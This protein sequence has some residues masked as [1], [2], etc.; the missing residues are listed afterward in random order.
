MSTWEGC[1]VI[2]E[3]FVFDCA[4]K[5]NS[6]AQNPFNRW[7]VLSIIPNDKDN[8][9]NATTERTVVENKEKHCG[10]FNIHLSIS[11]SLSLSLSLSLPPSLYLSLSVSL[12]S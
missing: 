7:L 1:L 2:R 6:L 11:I 8:P 10:I 12:F 9:P 3:L 5:M 4:K